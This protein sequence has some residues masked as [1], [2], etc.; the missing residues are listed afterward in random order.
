MKYKIFVKTLQNVI[1][2]Y[3]VDE[4]KVIDG[5]C[6]FMDH[7]KKEPKKFHSSRCE[8]YEIGGSVV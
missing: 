4:Y 2:N 6:C 5:F 1:L 8:I 3:S 7:K